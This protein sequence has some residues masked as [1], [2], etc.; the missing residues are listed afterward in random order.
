MKAAL[1]II[2]LAQNEA[3][4]LENL[5]PTLSWAKEIILVNDHSIDNTIKVS[6]KHRAKIVNIKKSLTFSKLRNLG[7]SKAS[8]Q[9][10]LFIDA[11]ERVGDK[12]K[13][14]ILSV[15]KIKNNSIKG[16]FLKRQDYFLCKKL[17]HGETANIK[18]LRLAQ[19]GSGKWTRPVH[20]VWNI[21]GPKKTLTNVLEHSPHPTIS[22]F[23]S[24]INHYTDIEANLRVSQKKS[25]NFFS[26]L[27]YPLAKFFVNYITNLGFLD[28]FPGLIMAY[29][30]SLHSLIVRIKLY[31]KTRT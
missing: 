12:L 29:I 1:S 10:V 28:G 21:T 18:L 31:E 6:K 23:L 20:E 5:L 25:W 19:K 3:K 27:A 17:T 30:M 16:Y 11:D 24:Q 14:E 2:I 7:L 26:T 8:N 13:D 15:I 9:W 4:N 22:Q